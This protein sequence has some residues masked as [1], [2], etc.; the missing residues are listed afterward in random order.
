MK[1]QQFIDLVVKMRAAQK[2]FFRTHSHSD[3]E[4]SRRLEREVDNALRAS[5]TDENQLSLFDH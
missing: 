5:L 3:Y 1:A 4:E 2:A